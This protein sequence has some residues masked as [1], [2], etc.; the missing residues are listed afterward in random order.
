MV[1]M[2]AY[3]HVDK[4]DDLLSCCLFLRFSSCHSLSVLKRLM[5]G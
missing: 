4:H 1:L 2:D 5:K 3:R